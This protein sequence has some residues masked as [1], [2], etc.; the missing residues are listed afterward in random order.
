MQKLM[1]FAALLFCLS[2]NNNASEKKPILAY[3]EKGCRQAA[4]FEPTEAVWLLWSNYDHKNGVSNASVTLSII[5]AL[6][7]YT[8]VKLVFANDSIFQKVLPQLP[9][10]ALKNKTLETVILPYREFWARDMGPAF[11]L[12]DGRLAIADFNFNGWG[13][14]ETT[15]P[16]TIQDEKLDEKIAALL[17]IPVVSTDLITEGGDHEVNGK[18]TLILTESVEKSRNPNMTL[19]QIEAEFK[20]VLG[21]KK[22]IWLKQGL[23]EDDNTCT[24]VLTNK[25]GEKVYNPLTTNGHCDEYVRFVNPT[26]VLLAEVDSTERDPISLENAKRLAAAYDILKAA[27]D[28]DG[29]PLSI[30]RIPLPKHTFVD[31]QSGDG[32][33]DV[34]STFTYKDGSVF[35]K[36]KPVKIITASSYLNFL[37]ANDC[38]LMPVYWKT[39]GDLSVKIRD[40]EALLVLQSVFPKKKIIPIDALAVNMGGGGIHCISRN[41]PVVNQ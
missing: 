14:N 29:H 32:V 11:I 27:T 13:Y 31:L 20:R 1:F 5:Q 34:I 10:N 6:L 2:C 26:T 7:P 3:P 36:G 40:E 17:H 35:P 8:H 15:D 4:E 22:I 9:S 39:G 37:I 30:L 16:T 33:Y 18:G 19:T 23:Y 12:K 28:Q 21:A 38:V 24:K 41:Q 25:E